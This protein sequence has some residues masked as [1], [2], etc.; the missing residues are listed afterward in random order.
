MPNPTITNFVVEQPLLR[1]IYS[2]DLIGPKAVA[3]SLAKET[4]EVESGIVSF[5]PVEQYDWL[6]GEW[7]Q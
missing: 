4:C 3:Y 6:K 1:P 2:G 7:R 5:S